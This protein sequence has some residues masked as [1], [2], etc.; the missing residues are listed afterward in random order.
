MS[1]TSNTREWREGDYFRWRWTEKELACRGPNPYWCAS[2]IAI[3]R[4]GVLRDTYWSAG[5]TAS[6]WWRREHADEQLVLEF[7]A[8]VDD[9]VVVAEHARVRD[10]DWARTVYRAEDLVDL[11]HSN[12]GTIYIRK[13][14]K[15]CLGV[16]RAALVRDRQEAQRRVEALDTRI[17]IMDKRIRDAGG[18]VDEGCPCHP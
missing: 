1:S 9:L 12:G 10:R 3:V 4:K 13:G 7:V 2:G 17:E 15:H 6:K 16:E 18:T 14:A 11:S 5:S 8:N